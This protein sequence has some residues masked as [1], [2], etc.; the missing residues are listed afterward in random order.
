[1]TTT[2]KPAP[3]LELQRALR[4]EQLI[5][6]GHAARLRA[7]RRRQLIQQVRRAC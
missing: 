6:A 2:T 5:V 1:M 3:R 4:R 7:Q